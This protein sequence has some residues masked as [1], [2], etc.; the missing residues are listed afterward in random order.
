MTF[1]QAAGLATCT[2]TAVGTNPGYGNNHASNAGGDGCAGYAAPISFTVGASAAN[3]ALS[4]PATTV[5]GTAFAVSTTVHDYTGAASNGDSI[6]LSISPTPTSF[7]CTGGTT[8]T[9][10]SGSASFGNCTVQGAVGAYTLKAT[11]AS[12]G[13]AWTAAT[14]LTGNTTTVVTSSPSSSVTGQAVTFTATVSPTGGATGTETGNVVFTVLA[15]GGAG[16]QVNCT[17]SNTQTLSSGTATCSI[18]AGLLQA[19]V[20]PYAVTAAYGGGSNFNAST[21]SAY[22]QVVA[23]ASTTTVLASSSNPSV[24]GAAV[25]Y[26]ATVATVSP[27]Q[28]TPTGTV[29]FYDGGTPISGCTAQTLNGSSPDTAT[30]AIASGTY[31]L[32]T[33]HSITATY[34]SDGNFSASS[35]SALTQVVQPAAANKVLFA[36]QPGTFTAGGT[37]SSFAVNVEDTY[38][39]IVTTSGTTVT[40]T[41]SVGSFSGLSPTTTSGVAAFSAL[42]TT[43]AGSYTV[44][45]SSTGLTSAVSSSFTVNP[46]A[47]SKV[48]FTTAP[49][50]T[51]TAGSNLTSFAV[52]VEDTYGNVET[53]SNTGNADVINL[54]VATGRAHRLGR[55]GHGLGRRGHVLLDGAAHGGQLH[56]DRHRRYALDHHGHL[57]AGHGDLPDHT[58]QGGLHDR[59]AHHRHGRV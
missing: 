25:T 23:K 17:T 3:S 1:A 47:P 6:T 54:T 21:S 15:S 32:A 14:T 9:S 7:S 41:P 18:A 30:C 12:G 8:V 59:S 44:T 34:S 13:Q 57:V 40:L 26:T 35:A 11:D 27:G 51:G 22:S 45:A 31:T 58:E 29:E 24:A 56:D 28:G 38:G 42:S 46:A 10:A 48:V 55:L 39:N 16:A 36:S 53:G 2:Q 5:S 19:S 49:P 20:T 43:T 4:V 50:T 37:S 52:S 33:S